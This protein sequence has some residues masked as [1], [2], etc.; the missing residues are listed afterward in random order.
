[1]IIIKIIVLH[2]IEITHTLMISL[3]GYSANYMLISICPLVQSNCF[4]RGWTDGH[5]SLNG[6]Q[7]NRS[8]PAALVKG[9]RCA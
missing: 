3:N 8:Y 7:Y 6:Q 5:L 9:F 4:L 2:F 1:M